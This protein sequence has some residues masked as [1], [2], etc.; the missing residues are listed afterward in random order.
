MIDT[1]QSN[2]LIIHYTITY[3]MSSCFD[4]LLLLYIDILIMTIT[5]VSTTNSIQ[6]DSDKPIISPILEVV[7]IANI[8]I[9]ELKIDNMKY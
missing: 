8:I 3:F 5:H 7:C 6:F 1:A 4:F 2:Y 9:I